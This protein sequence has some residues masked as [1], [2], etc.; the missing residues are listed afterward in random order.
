[1]EYMVKPRDAAPTVR[2]IDTYCE[3]YKDLFVEVRA[4]EC[5]KYLHVGLIS[6]LKRKS[7]PEIAKIVGLENEQGLHHFITKSPWSAQELE[8]RRLEIILKVLE[9][10][11]IDVIVDE[12]GDP[13]KGKTTDYVKRQYIG[14]LGKIENGIVS[15][16]AY[17]HYQGVTF[18]LKFKIFKP[19]ERLK[20]GDEYKSKP[21]L[22]A[23]MIK[24]LKAKGFKIKRVL[25]DSLYGESETN[26]LSVLD[27]LEIE[28][29]VAIRSN[30]GVWLP[31]GQKVRAN[32]W[33]E[34]EHQRSDQKIEKRYIR[35]VIYGRKRFIRYWEIT[36]DCE[37]VPD[38][39][40]WL[41][42]TKVANIKYQEVGNIYKIRAWVEYGFKQSK[43]ELGWADFRVTHYPQIE[44][45][46]QIVMSAY[47]MISLHTDDLNP[48]VAPIE[49]KWQKHDW[50]T[51]EKG[52]KNRLNNLRLILQPSLSFNLMQGWLKV[53]PIPQLSWGFP[54]LIAVMNEFDC[55]RYLVYLW[56]DFSYSSA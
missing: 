39:S 36:T 51:Q 11:E 6:N 15:V 13:K 42:M 9:G 56:D 40:T 41:V 25:A 33:R 28:Y 53:F 54:R 5:F 7:L 24:E 50:W 38:E 48:W 55:L 4:Y 52:W 19:K 3:L 43:S 12:T 27:E 21:V 46:W 35:E 10:N 18:P 2:F 49:E 1:M 29:V 16:N 17:G 37:T 32:K 23:E 14:N 20:E 26:F 47:L 44:K 31:K 34:F 45:W 8:E 30:H 22:G